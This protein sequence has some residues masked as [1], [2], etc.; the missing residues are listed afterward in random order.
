MDK[1]KEYKYIILIGLIILGFVFYWTQIRPVVIKKECFWVTEITPAHEGMPKAEFET[2]KRV[3]EEICNKE[4]K[5][6]T[7]DENG[8]NWNKTCNIP[9]VSL[10]L[11]QPEK[12]EIRKAT[13]KEYKSCLK[14][15]GL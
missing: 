14:E 9:D 13:D 3:A 2:T 11:P 4:S 6:N 15:N 7:D 8:F 5:I 12:K 1:I 10:M